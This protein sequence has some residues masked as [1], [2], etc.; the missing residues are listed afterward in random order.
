MTTTTTQETQPVASSTQ[1]AHPWRASARTAVSVL[2]TLAALFP[3]I[4]AAI[5]EVPGWLA[6]VLAGGVAVAGAVTRVMAIPAV[7]EWLGRV[8]LS[9]QPPVEAAPY[10]RHAVSD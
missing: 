7:N 6:Q 1:E 2:V 9:A 4:V 8:K 10:G 5:G 3:A